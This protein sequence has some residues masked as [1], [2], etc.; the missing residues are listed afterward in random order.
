MDIDLELQEKE[1]FREVMIDGE[2]ET[3][4]VWL[5][6][7]WSLT[8]STHYQEKLLEGYSPIYLI[9]K[10]EL[11]ANHFTIDQLEDLIQRI[12]HMLNPA[13]VSSLLDPLI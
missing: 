2:Y 11:V 7:D 10:S 6:G 1:V 9:N 12:E 5:D 3:I 13:S 4:A 8:T